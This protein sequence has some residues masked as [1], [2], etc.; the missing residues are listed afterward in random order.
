MVDLDAAGGA[1]A[2][3]E[4]L[5]VLMLVLGRGCCG[6]CCCDL[7]L[8]GC[9]ADDDGAAAALSP[10]GLLPWRLANAGF[11]LYSMAASGTVPGCWGQPC[12]ALAEK[13]ELAPPATGFRWGMARGGSGGALTGACG[14]CPAGISGGIVL[15]R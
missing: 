10:A 14:L 5:R 8:L 9:L 12:W 2:A 7:L 1:A 4:G 11:D 3:A 15:A 6:C 13:E